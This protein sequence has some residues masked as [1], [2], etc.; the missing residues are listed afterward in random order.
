MNRLEEFFKGNKILLLDGATG[1]QLIEKGLQAGECPDL[2]NITKA[3][4]IKSIALSY[5]NA[6]S[7]AVMTN[8]FGGSLIKLKRYGLEDKVYELNYAAVKNVLEVMP[9]GKLVLADIGPSGEMLEP[10]GEVTIEEMTA[11][12]SLQVKAIADAGIDGFMLE[13]FADI[14]EMEC[15]INAIREHTDLPIIGSLTFNKSATGYHTMMGTGIEEA[16]EFLSGKGLFAIGSNCGNGLKNMIE[17]G[18]EMRKHSQDM[19]IMVKPNAG[20]PLLKDGKTFYT[21]DAEFFSNN[22]LDLLSFKPSFIGGCCGT[23]PE[24]IKAMRKIIE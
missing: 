23:T 13:T 2:W 5:Y 22:A 15:A 6:G 10:F 11:S 16:V 3:E 7:D 19:R 17:V 18:K 8:T 20:E 12:F 14:N 4:V 21:E 24:H 9:E 1:T